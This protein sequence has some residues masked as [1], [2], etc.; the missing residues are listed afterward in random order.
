[1]PQRYINIST[2]ASNGS[3][4]ANLSGLQPY[5]VYEFYVVSYSSQVSY[6]LSWLNIVNIWPITPICFVF[7]LHPL[8]P[9]LSSPTHTNAPQLPFFFRPSRPTSAL[10][11]PLEPV[12]HCRARR[13]L[14]L[15]PLHYK[16]WTRLLL[17]HRG[18]CPLCG[19]WTASFLA[20]LL[21]FLV[22]HTNTLLIPMKLLIFSLL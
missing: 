1:M 8:S 2:I 12:V 20:L 10:P 17:L 7:Q 18:P 22:C 5:I 19:V 11:P 21:I 9:S 13:P 4:T 16:L 3:A 6:E 14:L 15:Y